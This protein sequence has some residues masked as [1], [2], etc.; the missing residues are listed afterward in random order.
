LIFESSLTHLYNYAIFKFGNIELPIQ[1]ENYTMP[2]A[3]EIFSGCGGLTTGLEQAG[4]TILSAVEIDKTAAT[5][6]SA[7]HPNVD[8][9]IKDVR[10]V[11]SSYFLK[12]HNMTRGQLDLLAGC[13]PCQGFSRLR[14]GNSGKDD[15]RNQLIF[16]FIRLVRGL[17]PKAIF[18]ENVPGLI[19][20]D[21]GLKIFE[22]VKL[23]LE[24]LGYRI[25][26]K[27]IDTAN[28]GIPQFRKRFVLLGT[29]YKK[30]SVHIPAETHGAPQNNNNLLPWR[31]VRD[32]FT[33]IPAL[34]NGAKDTNI[35]LHV[36]SK[37]GD[38]NLQRIRAVPH[39]GGSRDSFPPNLILECHKNY[40]QGFRDVYGR[41]RW[42]YPSPTITGGCTNIT[43]GRFVHPTED[44]GISLY[45]AAMLQTFPPNYVFKGNFGQ[46]SLQIGNAVPVELARIMG[47]QLIGDLRLV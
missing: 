39:D 7:N 41:M 8:L 6:Y 29:R 18:M 44:R 13:S 27:I 12:K 20:S 32:A 35:P 3:I 47:V 25:D 40:P 34:R 23:D 9:L 1:Q 11:P 2:I 43:R 16:E 26:Y 38:I 5:T 21:Y 30:R 4:F 19:N 28:Y 37:N 31:T 33:G 15:P 22:M 10:K 45:E 36:C 17:Y 24:N 14:K 42:N 46:I